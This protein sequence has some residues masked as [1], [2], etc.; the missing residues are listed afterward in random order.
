MADKIIFW[1]KSDSTADV[2]ISRGAGFGIFQE[3]G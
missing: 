3:F 2:S 1:D